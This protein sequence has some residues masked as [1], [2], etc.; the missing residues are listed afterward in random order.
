MN[1]A[2][3]QRYPG[4]R[5]LCGAYLH[6]D[7]AVTDSSPEAAVE[8]FAR[9]VAPDVRAQALGDVVHL[10]STRRGERALRAALA[11]L[12]CAY[13]PRQGRRATRAWLTR[14]RR[15]LARRPA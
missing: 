3:A 6:E 12:G 4:L 15:V 9:E 8:R 1:D 13:E 5:R 10:L 2:L 14:V 11:D 7:H